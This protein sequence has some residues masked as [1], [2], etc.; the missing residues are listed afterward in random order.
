MRTTI[1]LLAM[2]SMI[3]LSG[4]ATTGQHEPS[5]GWTKQDFSKEEFLKDL[6][7]CQEPK[8]IKEDMVKYEADIDF[9]IQAE[10]NRKQ[11]ANT[12]SMV[13]SLIETTLKSDF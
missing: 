4:C 7:Q 8:Y 9:C 11:R 12:L 5:K 2:V 1:I 3:L 6:H 13:S 10:M